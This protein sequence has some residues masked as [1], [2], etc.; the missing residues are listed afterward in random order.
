MEDLRSTDNVSLPALP[1]NVVVER[2]LSAEAPTIVLMG[3]AAIG[4]CDS[5]TIEATVASPRAVTM[6]YYC[7]H[8]D[9]LNRF[10]ES[11][12]APVLARHSTPRIR[13]LGHCHA[14]SCRAVATNPS[15]TALPIRC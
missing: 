14:T 11:Q 15:C 7:L 1:Q 3:P 10:V 9:T 5:A 4:T 13:T 8:D 2:P 12:V 6:K